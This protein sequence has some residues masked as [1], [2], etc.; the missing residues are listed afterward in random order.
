MIDVVLA[1]YRNSGHAAALVDLLDA[2]ARDP[3]GGGTPLEA[4]V[5][6]GLPAAL[7]ARPQ[8]FSVLAYDGAQPVGLI[9]CIE[10]FSTFACQPLVNVHD[11]VVLASH[12]G[13]RVAQQMFAR[14]EQEARARGACKLTLEV[15]SGNEPALRSYEREGFMNY[16]LDPAFGHAVF[17]QKKL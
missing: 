14:V 3:A 17:L 11:V 8:A 15:L 9:N 13:R 7:A 4:A 10:G 6:A 5:C 12:R 16:Q 1:D 2:Y